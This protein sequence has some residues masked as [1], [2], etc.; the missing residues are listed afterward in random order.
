LSVVYLDTLLHPAQ[1]EDKLSVL[2]RCKAETTRRNGR[3]AAGRSRSEVDPVVLVG[4][5]S[6]RLIV[7]THHE[8]DHIFALSHRD[9]FSCISL[10]GLFNSYK[11]IRMLVLADLF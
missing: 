9:D 3:S 4:T 1:N 8:V 11:W 10:E 6:G 5:F 7:A 2:A